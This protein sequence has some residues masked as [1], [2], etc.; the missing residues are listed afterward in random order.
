MGFGE[1]TWH[2][3]VSVLSGGEYTRLRLARLLVQSP[4][5]L[6]LD[7]PTNHLDFCHPGMAGKF[8][9]RVQGGGA[10]GEP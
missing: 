7:E 3:K 4:E 8:P 6:V 10:G 5:V 1:D 2:K 9:G